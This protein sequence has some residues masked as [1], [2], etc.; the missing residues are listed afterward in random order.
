MALNDCWGFRRH[1]DNR[2]DWT[3]APYKKDSPIPRYQHWI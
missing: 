1:R 3:P 2:V